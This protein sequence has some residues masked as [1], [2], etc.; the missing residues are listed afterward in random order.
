M[1]PSPVNQDAIRAEQVRELFSVSSVSLVTSGLL[2]LL[3]VIVQSQACG[4]VPC[5]MWLG[6]MMAVL[7][8]RHGLYLLWLK[9]PRR[10]RIESWLAY[11]RL[12]MFL[13]G[14]C[15]G[16]S[17]VMLFPVNDIYHQATLAYALA[18][19]TVGV[20]GIYA[21]EIVGALLYVIPLAVPLTWRFFTSNQEAGAAMGSMAILFVGFVI[22]TLRG[23][24]LQLREHVSLRMQAASGQTM[25]YQ[26]DAHLRQLSERLT[27]L[28]EAIPDAILFKDGQGRWLIANAAAKQLFKLDQINW[29]GKTEQEL[30]E[31]RPRF[32]SLHERYQRD[33]ELAWQSGKLSLFN[34]QIKGND[35]QS[36]H[37]ELRR[38]PLFDARGARKSMVIIGRDVTESLKN[39]Q[40]LR[41][42]AATFEVQE[43]IM[44]TDAQSRILRVNRAFTQLTGYSAE[45]AIGN[46]P[47]LL[48]SG[49]HD[50]AFYQQMW[51]SLEQERYWQGEIWN[52]RR[53]G[54]IFPEWL[55]ISSLLDEAGRVR[56]Y[57]AAFSDIT[58][59]KKAEEEIHSLAF[60][61]SLTGLPNR[62][63]L[64]DRLRQ[65]LIVSGRRNLHGAILFIDLDNFKTL[66]DTRGHDIGDM[67]LVDVARRLNQ[68]VR[69]Q[70]TVARLGGDEFI[71]VLEDLDEEPQLAAAH[72]E[73]V[74]EKI[75]AALNQPYTLA[76]RDYHSTPSIG[77]CLFLGQQVAVDEL[78]KRADTSMYEAKNAG[79]NAIRFFDPA[80]QEALERRMEIESQLRRALPEHQ[81]RLLLQPQVDRD[82]RILGA[83]ALLRWEH[84][85]RGLVTPHQFIPLAEES[86]MIVQIGLWV[87]EAACQQLKQWE[88]RAETRDLMM[89]VNVS[90]RQ[91]RQPDFVKQIHATLAATQA[92]PR[93]LKL[94][95]TESMVLDNVQDTIDKMTSLKA[96]GVQFAMDDFGMGYSSLAYLKRLPLN[97]VK[98]DR[99]F[100]R[101]IVTDPND[102][103]IVQTIIAMAGALG[104]DVVA[105]GVETDAQLDFLKAQGC[106]IFQGYLFSMPTPM[107]D[108]E[109]LL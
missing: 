94:E 70:D 85:Y 32:R 35:D 11:L 33:D 34:Q 1:K 109:R 68:C 81:F 14:S 6:M 25:L 20:M 65:A 48:K 105:E 17:A 100:V 47:A 74:A 102:A 92:N 55:T 40:E 69:E 82:R 4:W 27:A 89:A 84:P 93:R 26:K 104:L 61:D 18:G 77:V 12:G 5:L 43:G 24:S 46:T 56:N 107:A 30:A 78:I 97:Q 76:G 75:Q 52:R 62:R 13:T 67:L 86:G 58:Q 99:S 37:Y 60:Y 57:I 73:M 91:F 42:A 21:L 15:W 2:A 23:R 16:L 49:R 22:M 83:E 72:A 50:T 54:E 90:A 7:L 108:F 63:L 106:H 3:L 64:I 44:I 80:M 96:L 88:A 66:N 19:V 53:N 31:M 41:F 38:R 29:H 79:R 101:D 36:L 98:I 28:I 8:A 59:Y 71:L 9:K 45:D 103:A 39:E 51:Q 95:L 87:M 10:L